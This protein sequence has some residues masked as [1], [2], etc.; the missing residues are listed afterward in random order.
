MAM[1][2]KDCNGSGKIALFTSVV[3]CDCKALAAVTM[4]PISM[5]A[6]AAAFLAE[7]DRMAGKIAASLCVP[8]WLLFP[9][10]IVAPRTL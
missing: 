8:R 10:G 4:M 9:D 6:D 1:T 7:I 2:C 5:S 3:D